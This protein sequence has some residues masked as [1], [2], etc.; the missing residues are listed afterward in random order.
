MAQ[1]EYSLADYY[2]DRQF[3]KRAMYAMNSDVMG[4]LEVLIDGPGDKTLRINHLGARVKSLSMESALQ[5]LENPAFV[6]SLILKNRE[7]ISG[8]GLQ[9]YFEEIIGMIKSRVKNVFKRRY[10]HTARRVQNYEKNNPFAVWLYKL[11][12]AI[13]A[14][15]PDK[16]YEISE[17]ICIMTENFPDNRPV[18]QELQAQLSRAQEVLSNPADSQ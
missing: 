16:I 5:A 11:H 15:N 3:V 7:Y 14:K 13:L 1:K 8:N 18:I 10:E 4:K 9:L 17:R 12:S 2:S 6:R